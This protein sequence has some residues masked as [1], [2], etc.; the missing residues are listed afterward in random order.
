MCGDVI[1]FSSS[2]S[3]RK[4]PPFLNIEPIDSCGASFWGGARYIGGWATQRGLRKRA[5]LYFFPTLPIFQSLVPRFPKAGRGEKWKKL[6]AIRKLGAFSIESSSFSSKSQGGITSFLSAAAQI[7][8]SMYNLGPKF[9]PSTRTKTAEPQYFLGL[10]F[11]VG[12][13]VG[14]APIS[15]ASFF[16]FSAAQSSLGSEG[17]SPQSK[18]GP[19]RRRGKSSISSFPPLTAISGG[20]SG[21][22]RGGKEGFADCAKHRRL[23]GWKATVCFRLRVGLVGHW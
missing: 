7:E 9:C 22:G 4:P 2:S 19:K 14:W 6:F 20:H 5:L 8:I 11:A 18:E 15:L 23:F 21:G 10:D 17:Q 13:S 12:R 1:T 16:F 3:V